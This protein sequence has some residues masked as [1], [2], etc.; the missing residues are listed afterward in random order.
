MHSDFLPFQVLGKRKT[1]VPD[2]RFYSLYPPPP[3]SS[4]NALNLPAIKRLSRQ[5]SLKLLFVFQ[6]QHTFSR[7]SLSFNPAPKALVLFLL[8]FQDGRRLI[9]LFSKAPLQEPSP[10][11]I[12]QTRLT[13]RSFLQLGLSLSS[14]FVGLGSKE[15]RRRRHE[16]LYKT[17]CTSSSCGV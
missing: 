12:P 16:S 9:G 17:R 1:V 7:S 15:R 8:S 13:F 5:Y 3:T 11:K 14:Q 4:K 10:D 6:T 2:I